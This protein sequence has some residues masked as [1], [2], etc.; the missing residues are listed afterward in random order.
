MRLVVL[1]TSALCLTGANPLPFE[2]TLVRVV[3]AG[4]VPGQKSRPHVHLVNRVM[5]HLDKGELRIVNQDGTAR[6]IPFT[7]GQVR[8]DPKVGLH[9]SENTGGTAIRIIEV[10]LRN[11]SPSSSALPDPPPGATVEMTNAQ[12]RVL[13]LQSGDTARPVAITKP[14]L[15]VRLRDGETTFL[16]REDPAWTLPAAEGEW[17]VVELR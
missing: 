17:I 16:A 6:D 2:N 15:A 8:W 7:A 4:N 9:T 14:A 12:V 13:R 11:E 10:E 1:A 5:I 3:R